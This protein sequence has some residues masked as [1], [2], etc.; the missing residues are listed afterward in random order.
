MLTATNGPEAL[1]DLRPGPVRHRAHRRHDAGHGRLRGV[2]PPEGRP[3]DGP[4]ARR[5]G[6]GARPAERPAEGARG[7]RRRLPDQAR[8]RDGADGARAQP[9]PAQGRD[10]TNCAA[11][12][13]PRATSASPIRWRRPR[14][15]RGS[16]AASCSST[17]AR[18]P[19][20]GIIPTLSAQ[21]QRAR[22]SATRRRRCSPATDEAPDLVIVSLD[23]ADYDG[24]RAVQPAALARPHAAHRRADAGRRRGQRA[25]CCAAST[26]A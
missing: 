25:R 21:H 11:A 22:S 7:R 24:L 15:I 17:T 6:D 13:S 23:L 4:S 19:P 8:R 2:P 26:S 10:A 16:A 3:R 1:V 18:A 20:S 12:R 14:P 9:R 5:H